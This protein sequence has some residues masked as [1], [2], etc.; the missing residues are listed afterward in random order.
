MRWSAWRHDN[1]WALGWLGDRW[2]FSLAKMHG[3]VYLDLGPWRI[4]WE[5]EGFWPLFSERYG[6]DRWYGFG[7][8]KAH[9]AKRATR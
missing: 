1:A 7:R 2:W 5:R 9:R 6:Y 4:R 8:L 3:A